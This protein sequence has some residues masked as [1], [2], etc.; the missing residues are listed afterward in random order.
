[1]I[2][3]KYLVPEV[4]YDRSRDFQLMGRTYD[5]I[6][7]YL[8]TNIDTISNNP[9]SNDSDKKLINLVAST[10]GFKQLHNYNTD[11]LKA[12]CSVYQLAIRNKGNIQSL[13]IVLDTLLHVAGISESV[14]IDI[15]GPVIRIMVP[16]ELTDLTLFYDMLDYILPAGCSCF[17]IK[18]LRI[19]TPV[20]T[21]SAMEETHVITQNDNYK[22]AFVPQYQSLV[23][24]ADTAGG[25]N[26]NMT[27]MG[28]DENATKPFTPQS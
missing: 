11:Q 22:T 9:L 26:D 20:E 18:Q 24:P 17:I 1:M 23:A 15:T 25:R 10:L 2:N 21:E 8:K 7:N 3:T 16:P 13:K 28:Y 5:I 14:E 12:I 27:V 6:F 4:Y 19:T